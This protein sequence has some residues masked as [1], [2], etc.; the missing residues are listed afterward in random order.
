MPTMPQSAAGPRMEPPVSEPV[1][2]RMRPAATAAPV[3][4]E[5]PEVKWLGSHGLRAGGQGRSKLGPPKA[6]SWVASL[7][8]MTVPASA[9]SLTVVASASGTQFCSSL[10]CAVVAMPAVP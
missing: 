4:E 3:P 8:S 6:N 10:E 7:P 1:P 2:P 9:R 5:D